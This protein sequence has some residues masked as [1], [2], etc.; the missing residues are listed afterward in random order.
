[1]LCL[2][3][4]RQYIVTHY[5]ENIICHRLPD[6]NVLYNVFFQ[7]TT[8][9]VMLQG[10]VTDK[11]MCKTFNCG[12]GLTIITS[13]GEADGVCATT[14]GQVIGQVLPRLAGNLLTSFQI[15]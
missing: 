5:E 14:G 13:Q 9:Q 7:F 2:D 11:E 8:S 1:M 3:A 15:V 4:M 6:R 12:I 10:G